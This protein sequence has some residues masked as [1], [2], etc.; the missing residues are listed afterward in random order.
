[1]RD[2]EVD[3]CRMTSQGLTVHSL[4]SSDPEEDIAPLL[5]SVLFGNVKARQIVQAARDVIAKFGGR[6]PDSASSLREITGIGPTLAEVL[7]IINRRSTFPKE[8]TVAQTTQ[9]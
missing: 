1:M 8:E 3:D 7:T 9:A 4:A 5:S 2:D 6:V